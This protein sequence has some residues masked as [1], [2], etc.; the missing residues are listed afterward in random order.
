MV[1]V[2]DGQFYIDGKPFFMY[3]GEIHYF[4]IP[5]KLWPKHLARAKE[6]GLNTVSSYIPW[7]WHQ[8]EEGIFDFEG[9]THPQRNLHLYLKEVEK[10]GLKFIA[11]VGPVSNG[12]LV[13][14]GV[15]TWLME[16]YP[17]IFVRGKEVINLPHVTLFSYL[18]PT[19]QKMVGKWYDQLLPIIKQHQH[20][21]G[22]IVLVQLCNEIGM[23]HWLNKAADYSAFVEEM[24]R[25]FLKQRYR[26]IN[27]L[28]ASYGT[29]HKD[30]SSV[31]QPPSGSDSQ[32]MNLLWDWMN[33]YQ[34]YLARYFNALYN[35]MK[36]KGI[37]LPVLANIPQFYDYDV[38]GRGVFS[39]MTTMMFREFPKYVPGVVFG[40]AYQMRRLDYENFHDVPI[41]TEVVRLI[42]N[43]GIPAVCAELQSGIMRDRPKL[44]NQDVELNLKTSSAS[45]LNGVNA[46]MF[47]G[48][49]NVPGFGAFGTYHEW[50]AA[51]NP[52][53]EKSTHFDAFV[54]FSGFVKTF[55]VLFSQTKKKNDT[56]FGFYAPYYT[57]EYLSGPKIDHWEW[58]KAQLYFDGLGRLLQIANIN[59]DFVDIQRASVEE[60]LKHRSLWVFTLDFMDENT[61]KKLT[62]YVRNGGTLILNP[63]LPEKNLNMDK[64][65]VLA[66]YIG[67]KLEEKLTRNMFFYIGKQDYLATGELNQY[68]APKDA[69]VIGVSLKQKPCLLEIKKDS[70][71]VLLI[72]AGINHMF[73]YSIDLINEF[74][75]KAGVK[76]A[77]EVARDVNVMLRADKTYGFLFLANYHDEPKETKVRMALPGETKATVFPQEGTIKMPNRKAYMLPLNAPL[78]SGDKIRYSTFEILSIKEK[79]K[80]KIFKVSGARGAAGEMELVTAC[81][82][83]SV[84]G[85]KAKTKSAA[86]RLR[87]NIVL[88]GEEQTIV[89]K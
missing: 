52:E 85:K 87:L 78:A 20:P 72:G 48:G 76:P 44:Y 79:G 51:V 14:E 64:C 38:R 2:K 42:T 61:Q 16:R 10:A 59:C 89:V 47:S 67:T 77:V 65:A 17:E 43:P 73:D 37:D 50:Q 11:R 60:L 70:G 21:A 7:I 46:Y 71:K 55:G 31:E 30:F 12:E 36:S 24:Y 27:K 41:T 75:I 34:D 18:N 57:T 25:E 4:R 58:A 35:Q 15:P 82:G 68:A 23:V 19:F 45:G 54:N 49:R 74:A 63:A 26:D 39:P 84:D 3:S 62:E 22:N 81:R 56:A 32:N 66:D 1:E 69:S 53:A 88:T 28:N 86:G 5:P 13:N 29:N 80:Q 8:P 40:G 6:A 33:F 83:A 9:K